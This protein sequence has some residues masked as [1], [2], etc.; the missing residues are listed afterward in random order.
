[1]RAFV[2]FVA[3]STPFLLPTF[4]VLA[5]DDVEADAALA[6]EVGCP[7]ALTPAPGERSQSRGAVGAALPRLSDTG[8][9]PRGAI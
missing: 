5:K 8:T 7:P 2:A 1:M 4:R 6:S 3:Q 9:A